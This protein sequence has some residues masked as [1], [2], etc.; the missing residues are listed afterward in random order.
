M[1]ILWLIDCAIRAFW[2]EAF[3]VSVVIVLIVFHYLLSDFI[4]RKRLHFCLKQTISA[5]V[6]IQIIATLNFLTETH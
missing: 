6:H 1:A 5:E 3:I 4:M 2:V